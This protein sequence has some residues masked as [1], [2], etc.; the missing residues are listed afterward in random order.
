[1]AWGGP[2][3]PRLAKPVRRNSRTV[4]VSDGA[5]VVSS[6]KWAGF[7]MCS[8][9]EQLRFNLNRLNLH[10]CHFMSVLV[11]TPGPKMSGSAWVV[12]QKL[13]QR[14][15][16]NTSTWATTLLGKMLPQLSDFHHAE[17]TGQNTRRCHTIFLKRCTRKCSQTQW[18]IHENPIFIDG[19]P[20]KTSI[21]MGLPIAVFDHRMVKSALLLVESR[22]PKESYLAPGITPWPLPTNR[23]LKLCENLSD[24]LRKSC[25]A[26]WIMQNH[27]A[28]ICFFVVG[29]IPNGD[30][31]AIQP[32]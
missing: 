27:T 30:R 3:T 8:C 12:G 24:W 28:S 21:S 11:A 6:D 13:R 15:K 23:L 10:L 18:K 20:I 25:S 14:G 32:I 19:F 5:V 26:F 7:W 16:K 2:S 4:S 17:K 31:L 1:M 22:F 9:C 29:L